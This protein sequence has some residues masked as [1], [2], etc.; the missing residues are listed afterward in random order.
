VIKK[1]AINLAKSVALISMF[2][3]PAY[4]G[5]DDMEAKLFPVATTTGIE[6]YYHDART[7]CLK[8]F[9]MKHR[10]ATPVSFAWWVN[11]VGSSE[12]YPLAAY[13]PL[14]GSSMGSNDTTK[15]SDHVQ[16]LEQCFDMPAP[17]YGGVRKLHFG[18]M[19]RY[20]VKHNLWTVP[21]T[22]P[23]FVVDG[24]TVTMD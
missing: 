17:L 1:I 12:L 4:I 20:K 8:Q 23:S 6:V 11:E 22:V 10:V 9:I 15:K 2:V 14:T 21:R 18:A 19:G 3:L 13:S 16:F 7:V 5:A 24:T